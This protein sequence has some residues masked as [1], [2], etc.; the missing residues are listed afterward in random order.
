MDEGIAVD[1][2]HG[3]VDDADDAAQHAE[4]D[5]A[6]DVA[7]PSFLLL[8]D[9][10]RLPHHV[11]QRDDQRA[12]ADAPKAVRH[13]PPECAARRSSRHAAWLSRAEIPAPV[14]TGNGAVQRVLDPLADPVSR[15]RDEH[16][17]SDD[18]CAR[19]SARA[20]AARTRRIAH[21]RPAVARLVLDVH[22]NQRDGV[23]RPKCQR[24]EAA[25]R[26]RREDMSMPPGD[27]HRRLQHH[28]AKGDA[29]DPAHEA[30]DAEN[31][32]Q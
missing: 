28:D 4:R 14:Q 12:E 27:I 25:E 29:R 32:K 15:K 24:R 31:G 2:L 20:R 13:A 16:Q 30:D 5:R 7:F 23:P 17:Q 6:D 26:A 21:P 10:R 19:T 9:A 18:F 11:D 22:R 1:E 3:P 8:R